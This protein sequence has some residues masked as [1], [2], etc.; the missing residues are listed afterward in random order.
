MGN[1]CPWK[2]VPSPETFPRKCPVSVRT[3]GPRLPLAAFG[4]FLIREDGDHLRIH[5][6]NCISPR[7]RCPASREC[8]RARFH[9]D[10]LE[11]SPPPRRCS[12]LWVEGHQCH[13][14]IGRRPVPLNLPAGRENSWPARPSRLAK[15]LARGF[16]EPPKHRDRTRSRNSSPLRGNLRSGAR[17]ICSSSR[18]AL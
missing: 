12:V 10:L 14:R 2:C 13:S 16:D 4:H 6:C 15:P 18:H 7:G 17:S 11:R 3:R 1:V 5:A 8:R 9:R